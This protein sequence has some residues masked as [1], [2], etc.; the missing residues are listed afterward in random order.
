LWKDIAFRKTVEATVP[1][2]NT[3]FIATGGTMGLQLSNDLDP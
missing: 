2:F 1:G 3:I